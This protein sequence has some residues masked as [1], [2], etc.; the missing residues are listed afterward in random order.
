[1]FKND[2]FSEESV[3][4]PKALQEFKRMLKDPGLVE[5]LE[6]VFSFL[7]LYYFVA[8]EAFGE[9]IARDVVLIAFTHWLETRSLV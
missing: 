7:K 4:D 3:V 5:Y 2:D 9:E 6:A 1:M 8:E